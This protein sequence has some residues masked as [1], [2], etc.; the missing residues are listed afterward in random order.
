MSAIQIGQSYSFRTIKRS[1]GR[2]DKLVEKEIIQNVKVIAKDAELADCYL[3]IDT[4]TGRGH[5]YPK[6][7][8]L[9]GV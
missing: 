7:L 6:S 4:D 9:R 1:I 8:I 3:V 5:T 2:N